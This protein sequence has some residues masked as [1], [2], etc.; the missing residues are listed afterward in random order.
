MFLDLSF[1]KSFNFWLYCNLFGIWALTKFG[2]D[3]FLC[4]FDLWRHKTS[5]LT[6]EKTLLNVEKCSAFMA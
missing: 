6:F 5:Y 3:S 4:V 1:A 2:K